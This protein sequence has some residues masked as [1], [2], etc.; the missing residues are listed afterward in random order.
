[1]VYL[2]HYNVSSMI[3]GS[4]SDFWFPLHPHHLAHNRQSVEVGCFIIPLSFL[5]VP[6]TIKDKNPA[7]KT[8]KLHNMAMDN[9]TASTYL[10]G[11][12]PWSCRQVWRDNWNRQFLGRWATSEGQRSGEGSL[13]HQRNSINKSTKWGWGGN[14]RAQ[15]LHGRAES[16]KTVESLEPR[17]GSSHFFL[18]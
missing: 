11:G 12:W 7:G 9:S 17:L 10:L 18:K 6:W 15:W 3:P 1:M 14:I 2:S 5:L 4:M 8:R 13:S 16:V